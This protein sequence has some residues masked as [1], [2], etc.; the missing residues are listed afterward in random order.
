M[1]G[2]I[3]RYFYFDEERDAEILAW[4]ARQPNQ[5]HIVR[6]LIRREI[7]RERSEEENDDQNQA[8]LDADTLRQVIR[9]ELARVSVQTA[10]SNDGQNLGTED[11]ETTEMLESLLGSWDFDLEGQ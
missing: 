3:R 10:A 6:R 1:T 4:L 2:L 8:G 5:S 11:E 7:L 9:E